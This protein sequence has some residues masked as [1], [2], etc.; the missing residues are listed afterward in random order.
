MMGEIW[1]GMMGETTV[2]I[3]GTSGGA[4]AVEI[5]VPHVPSS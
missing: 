2:H 5:I 4:H 1:T 3:E